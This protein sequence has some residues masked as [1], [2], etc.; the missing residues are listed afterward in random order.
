ML[1]TVVA[2]CLVAVT[3]AV[4]GVLYAAK[5]AIEAIPVEVRQARWDLD[6]QLSE[7]RAQALAEAGAQLSAITGTL[8]NQLTQTRL[9]LDTQITG[10]RADLREV[11]AASVQ[12]VIE[13][14]D[15]L[16]ADLK[17]TLGNLQGIT[18][19]ANEATSI[20]FR[21]DALPAQLLGV[22]AAAKIT[23]G[24]TALTMRT[25]QEAAPG[26][27]GL[28][29]KIGSNS[30]AATAEAIGTAKESR[31]FLHNLADNVT[32]LPKWIRYPAQV[33]GLIGGAAVPVV[34]L[35]RLSTVS[36]TSSTAVRVIQ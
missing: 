29:N 19:H 18:E 30:D 4:C 10:T 31:R 3:I 34:T 20:L 8:D 33:V 22:T 9:Q 27:V 21:R 2:F 26:F 11:V 13:P 28:A 6:R 35:Q 5:G 16:R 12:A 15:G 17:P 32:P 25:F 7:F 24:Q 36:S 14:L 1:K 23:L